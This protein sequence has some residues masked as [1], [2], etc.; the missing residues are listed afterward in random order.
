MTG[1]TTG[2]SDVLELAPDDPRLSLRGQAELLREGEW[3]VPGRLPVATQRWLIDPVLAEK[4]AMPAGVR[5]D[6]RT[7]ATALHWPVEVRSPAG[8]SRAPAPFDVLVNGKLLARLPVDG[9]ATLAVE[10][11]AG[12]KSVR[13]WLPQ[14][15]SVRLGRVRLT[16]A[17]LLEPTDREPNVVLYGSSITQC[18]GASG[19]SETWPALV[20]T[21]LG[22][23][24]RCLGFAGEC[25]LDPM[26]ARFIRDCPADLISLCVGVNIHGRSSYSRRTFAAA[27]TGFVA[28]IRDGH[29]DT[30]LVLMTPIATADREHASND[31]G[32]SL[33]DLRAEVTAV[34]DFL[35][36]RGD[37]ALRLVNGLD[38]LGPGETGLLGDGLHPTPAGYRLMAERLTPLLGGCLSG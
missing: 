33:A 21:A 26:I 28:T 10:L 37:S 9:P 19:P 36:Q 27:L 25:H 35:Y 31:V 7:D 32:L 6:F 29:P 5:L 8:S 1:M 13:I 24:L 22:G 18:T 23:D 11:P 12:P 15:G 3:L 30:P 38:V 34:R 4:A 20:A 14:F 16:G 2:T 17:N